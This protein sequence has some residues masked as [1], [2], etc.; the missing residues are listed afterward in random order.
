[1][2]SSS[3]FSKLKDYGPSLGVSIGIHGVVFITLG[4]GFIEPPPY[5]RINAYPIVLDILSRGTKP[6]SKAPLPPHNQTEENN[7]STIEDPIPPGD[8]AL[9]TQTH[10]NS[11]PDQNPAAGTAEASPSYLENPNPPYPE[12]ARQQ[13]QE[14]TVLLL[15]SVNKQ[16]HTTDVQLKKSSGVAALDNAAIKS[17]RK[18]TFKPATVSFISIDSVVEIPIRFRLSE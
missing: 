14:G 13:G 11:L 15:V 4:W 6:S 12:S 9:S 7:P 5:H 17:V 16:G 3:I 8:T 10:P 18:W 1:M 2:C